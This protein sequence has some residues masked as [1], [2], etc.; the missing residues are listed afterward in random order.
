MRLRYI[1]PALLLS[2]LLTLCLSTAMAAECALCGNETGSED[3]LCTPCLLELLSAKAPASS[4][5]IT[6]VDRND[7]ASVTVTWSDED[8]N[9][10]YT[11]Y[12]ELLEAAPTAFGWTAVETETTVCTLNQL[13]PGVSYVVTV[14]DS[15]GHEAAATLF[16]EKPGMGNEIGARIRLKTVLRNG[17][18]NKQRTEFSAA[19]IA[20][21]SGAEHGL[22]V[23]LSYSMLKRSRHYAFHL[24]MKA[25]NG[26]TDVIYSGTLDLHHGRSY[27]PVWGFIPVDDYFTLLEEYYGGIPTGEYVV[28]L[29]FDG[30]EIYS[31][32][33]DMTE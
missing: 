18:V 5:T 21:D 24:V 1:I 29:F 13:A 26:F 27:V 32:T 3:Y 8:G 25:P 6:S 16:A 28:T 31:D 10:P 15:K 17:R 7:D 30:K 9:G 23:R 19:E 33:F 2:L 22:Y 11:V 20:S 12:Y 4:L 14:V